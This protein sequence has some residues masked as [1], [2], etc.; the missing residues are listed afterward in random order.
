MITLCRANEKG[1]S[2]KNDQRI[3]KKWL[4]KELKRRNGVDLLKMG[5][6]MKLDVREPECDLKKEKKTTLVSKKTLPSLKQNCCNV[7]WSGRRA[8]WA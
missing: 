5:Y 4:K 2:H 6:Q 3:F 1:M 8:R 7:N